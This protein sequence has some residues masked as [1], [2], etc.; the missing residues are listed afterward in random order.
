[1]DQYEKEVLRDAVRAFREARKEIERAV[2]LR[3]KPAIGLTEYG[4]G[5]KD[6]YGDCASVLMQLLPSPDDIDE[7][8]RLAND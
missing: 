2:E 4:E 5:R 7:M 3:G 1:M 8:D 6:G